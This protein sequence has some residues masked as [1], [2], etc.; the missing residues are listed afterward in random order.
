MKWLEIIKIRSVEML[1]K[2]VISDLVHQ[3]GKLGTSPKPSGIF[4]YHHAKLM[5]DL[6]IHIH[7]DTKDIYFNKSVIGG[8]IAHALKDF[9]LVSHSV[10]I[11]DDIESFQIKVP[12]KMEKKI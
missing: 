3:F 7:W 9:G 11:S 4:M 5:T 1:G 2:S 8:H 6:C 10:W 12:S